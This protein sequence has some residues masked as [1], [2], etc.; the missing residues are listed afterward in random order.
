MRPLTAKQTIAVL[1]KH[2]FI[3]ARKKGSHHIY[4][5]K[6]TGIAVPVPLHGE[7]KPIPI[8]TFLAIVKQTRIPKTEFQK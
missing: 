1:E 7:N 5:H 8:G 3:L 4:K 2:G 6:E